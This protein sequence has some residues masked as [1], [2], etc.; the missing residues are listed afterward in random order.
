MSVPRAAVV[1]LGSNSTRMLV[2][3]VTKERSNPVRRRIET[4]LFQGLDADGLLSTEAI[5]RAAQSAGD[6]CKM[7]REAG[8]GALFVLATSAAREARNANELA[9]AVRDPCQTEMWVISGELEALY[10]YLGAVSVLADPGATGVIDIGG[11][12]AEMVWGRD[13]EIAFSRSIPMGASRLDLLHP[14]RTPADVPIAVNLAADAIAQAPIPNNHP[15]QWLLVGGTGAALKDIALGLP[16]ASSMPDTYTID[17]AAIAAQLTRFAAL[18]PAER[19]LVPGL[20]HG[21]E[22]IY[23]TGLAVLLALM[24]ALTIDRVTVTLRNNTDG[25]LYWYALSNHSA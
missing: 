20:P 22:H 6:L 19:V 4:H 21:R 9:R 16:A 8:A 18:T 25:F 11:G 17:R 2:A 5:G 13:G 10:A 15:A 24:D 23:P 3:D 14:I 1:I 7:A 12:S